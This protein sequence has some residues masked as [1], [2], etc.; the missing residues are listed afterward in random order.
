VPGAYPQRAQEREGDAGEVLGGVEERSFFEKFGAVPVSARNA[1][2]LMRRGHA[3][4]L[5]H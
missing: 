3:V 5:R 1:A 4:L 2:K